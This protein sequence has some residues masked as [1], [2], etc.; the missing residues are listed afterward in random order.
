M[1]T[2]MMCVYISF[3]HLQK[4]SWIYCGG[5]FVSCVSFSID[6]GSLFFSDLPYLFFAP[7]LHSSAGA[8]R[9]LG[10][11]GPAGQLWQEAGLLCHGGAHSSHGG[12]RSQAG[13]TAL[14]LHASAL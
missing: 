1:S 12:S 5:S 8:S 2:L 13:E 10:L 7:F 9:V 11:P 6:T 4:H 14:F 3:I